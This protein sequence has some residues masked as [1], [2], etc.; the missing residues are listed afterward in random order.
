MLDKKLN[1][2]HYR[3]NIPHSMKPCRIN[4]VTYGLFIIYNSPSRS[5]NLGSRMAPGQAH[6]NW[7][8]LHM[9]YLSFLKLSRWIT[10]PNALCLNVA[11]NT[12]VVVK[13]GHDQTAYDQTVVSWCFV[14]LYLVFALSSHCQ[15]RTN[16]KEL[17][18]MRVYLDRS[19][20]FPSAINLIGLQYAQY[21]LSSTQKVS[22]RRRRLCLLWG[23][24]SII[25]GLVV[26]RP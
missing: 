16:G 25:T 12:S 23:D 21:M 15:A 11:H 17:E 2:I 3:R 13:V 6:S 7:T 4:I 26:N 14:Y 5:L 9:H 24:S 1:T 18:P 10:S 8:S 20:H 22:T 19:T